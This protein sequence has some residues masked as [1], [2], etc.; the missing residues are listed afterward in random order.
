MQSVH[1]SVADDATATVR[2]YSPSTWV[3][4]ALLTRRRLYTHP[5]NLLSNFNDYE[6][7]LWLTYDTNST[8]EQSFIRVVIK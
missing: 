6:D 8:L 4:T 1:K 7:G 5:C 2:Q 3:A